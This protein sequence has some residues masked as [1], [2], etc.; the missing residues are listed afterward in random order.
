[1][2]NQIKKVNSNLFQ[3]YIRAEN[4]VFT[5]PYLQGGF[6]ILDDI[7]CEITQT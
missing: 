3:I 6:A 2:V 4:F 7:E 1:M 5:S